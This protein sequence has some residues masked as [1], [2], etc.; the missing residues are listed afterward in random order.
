MVTK[1]QTDQMVDKDVCKYN[2]RREHIV[3]VVN[4]KAVSEMNEIHKEI[5]NNGGSQENNTRHQ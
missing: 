3:K 1:V 4:Q 2:V 5:V